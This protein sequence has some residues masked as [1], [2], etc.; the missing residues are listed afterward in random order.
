MAKSRQEAAAESREALL[1]AGEEMLVEVFA[2]GR[3]DPLE[4]LKPSAIAERAGRSK[5][6]LYHL[7]PVPEDD[8]DRLAA[9]RSA[10]LD[11]LGWR[12]AVDIE[13]VL[14]NIDDLGGVTTTHFTQHVANWL[15]RTVGPG[16]ER[17]LM[18]RMVAM[19]AITAEALATGSGRTVGPTP[20]R[21]RLDPTLEGFYAD[22]LRVTGREMVPPLTIAHLGAMLWA[23]L[24]G[25]ALNLASSPALADEVELE[26]KEG[27]WTSYAI[28]VDAIV[29]RVTRPIGGAPDPSPETPGTADKS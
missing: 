8:P 14:A 13:A 25:V 19:L 6:M 24:D 22:A 9:Y 4:V 21:L 23:A 27:V 29:A 3:L 20:G 15:I 1:R 5:G 17:A 7:W 16:G 2:E 26:G 28:I 18:H 10:L 12:T 11:R